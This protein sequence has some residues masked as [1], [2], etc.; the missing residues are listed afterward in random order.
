MSTLDDIWIDTMYDY[1]NGVLSREQ[2]AL[3]FAEALKPS[4]NTQIMPCPECSVFS[5]NESMRRW[6]WGFCPDC[7]RNL[8]TTA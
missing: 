6:G 8:S 5:R 3:K 1:Q 7:G 2:V 4:H